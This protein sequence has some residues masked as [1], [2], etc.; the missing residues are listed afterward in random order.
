MSNAMRTIFST[1]TRAS[2]ASPPLTRSISEALYKQIAL[3]FA[4]R[5]RRDHAF[6]NT[7]NLVVGGLQGRRQRLDRED[8]PKKKK[9]PI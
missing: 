3:I 2:R 9:S 8:W 6:Q 7:A 4:L 1:L 5:M